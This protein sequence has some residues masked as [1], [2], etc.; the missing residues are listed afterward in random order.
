MKT[1]RANENG[2]R[3]ESKVSSHLSLIRAFNLVTILEIK[4]FTHTL[5]HS[6]FH[7]RLNNGL[8]SAI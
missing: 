3:L 4:E 7:H 2:S 1:L 5:E 6:F 8:L